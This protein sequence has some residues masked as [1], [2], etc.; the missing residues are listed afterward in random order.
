M[1]VDVDVLCIMELLGELMVFVVNLLYNVL[2]LVLLYFFENFVYFKCGVVMVQV[3]VVEW[4]VVKLG[5][6]IYGL[7]S[8]KV[9]WY[10]EWKFFGMV[11]C[12]VFW[13]VFNVDSLFVG[14]D[15]FEGEWGLEQERC[16][17][18]QIVDVVFNQCCKM[19]CQ[20][21]FGIFGSFVVVIEVLIVVGV[22][23]IVCGEDFMVDDYQWIVWYVMVIE[24]FGV[25]G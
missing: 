24:G 7:L 18:F 4:L 1:V 22:V 9:V 8:V 6:K 3:E 2:V 10:G 20:V 14:F 23:F 19:F 13:L 15:C 25:S 21:L 11:F 17:M 5:L 16:C 12:Q